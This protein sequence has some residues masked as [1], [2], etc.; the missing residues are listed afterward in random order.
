MIGPAVLRFG[1]VDDFLLG[2]GGLLDGLLDGLTLEQNPVRHVD[3]VLPLGR[4]IH[5]PC[6][7]GV[8][9]TLQER[10]IDRV[11]QVLL[12]QRRRSPRRQLANRLQ[13]DRHG[14]R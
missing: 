11:F 1:R 4:L 2:A 8:F 6:R 9:E 13:P 14:F 12:G 3:G 7:M 10:C 5:E